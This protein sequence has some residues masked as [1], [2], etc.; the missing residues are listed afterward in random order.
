MLIAFL[1]GFTFAT[2]LYATLNRVLFKF[3]LPKDIY[4]ILKIAHLILLGLF[5]VVLITHI[6]DKHYY[7]RGRYSTFLILWGLLITGFC[8]SGFSFQRIKSSILNI[9][10]TLFHYGWLIIVLITFIPFLGMTV[11]FL[12]GP[13]AALPGKIVF[14]NENFRIETDEAPR[15]MKP[16][17]REPYLLI[18]KKGVLEVRNTFSSEINCDK[19]IEIFSAD[20]YSTNDDSA[21]VIMRFTSGICRGDNDTIVYSVKKRIKL[22]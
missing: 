22:N 7:L 19:W 10:L 12:L 20:A 3:Q 5:L 4:K 15:L 9:Y 8:L 14:S 13:Y 2:F 11:P 6:I 18:E 17:P 21:T 1:L 16:K